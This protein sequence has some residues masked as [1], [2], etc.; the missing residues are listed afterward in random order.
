MFDNFAKEKSDFLKKK[1]KS[2]KGYI[3]KDAVK[4]VDCINSKSD[5]YTTSSCAGRIVLLEMK[6]RKK[7]DCGWI[8]SKHDKV[9]FNEINNA[10]KHNNQ[11]TRELPLNAGKK[12]DTSFGSSAKNPIWFKQQPIILHVACRSLDAAKRL[13]E[14]ARKMFKHSGILSITDRKTTIEIIGS[15]KIDT[16]IADRDFIADE[17]YIKQLVKYA[18]HNFAENKRKSEMLLKI[19]RS[20]L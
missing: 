3:D 13:L 7:N 8:F 1:D 2:R 15:E 17:K 10:L 5:Y 18:N 12:E 19:L 14:A 4:I 20:N 6:S 11:K 16:I 9:N